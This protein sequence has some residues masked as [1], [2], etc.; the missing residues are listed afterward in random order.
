[1]D[2]FQSI[3]ERIDDI[4]R[5]EIANK[6][7]TLMNVLEPL[8]LSGFIIYVLLVFWSYWQNPNPEQ[9]MLD[10]IKRVMVWGLI[11]GFSINVGTY[12]N[13]V[14][15]IVMDLGDGLSQAFTGNAT[16]NASALDALTGQ[17]V[18]MVN[19]NAE[20]AYKTPGISE[21]IA[22]V[23]NTTFNNAIILIASSIFLVVA[24]A[25]IVLTKIFLALL[26]VIGPLFIFLGIFPA[27]RQFFMSWVNQVIN[28]SFLMLFVNVAGGFFISYI[29][30]VLQ[31]MVSSGNLITDN[32]IGL[33]GVVQIV[34]A[35]LL[36]VIVLLKLPELS[37]GIAGGVASNGFGSLVNTVANVKRISGGSKNSPSGGGGSFSK[38]K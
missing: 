23:I 35:T 25:Y 4:V 37:S 13:T 5:S 15:P 8:F 38:A 9:T 11:I 19:K 14:V 20:Q 24:A 30:S 34:L 32:I 29:D 1:M 6:A 3:F 10:V 36:F 17:I 16:S 28:Y 7:S 12:N 26:A 22:A 18:D 31:D 2:I 33:S 21:K 27:T